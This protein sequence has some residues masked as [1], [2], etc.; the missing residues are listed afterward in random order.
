MTN[1][2]QVVTGRTS[3][4]VVLAVICL[5]Q[6]MTTLD[7]TIVSVALPSIQESVGLTDAGRQ[8]AVTA[9]TL[10]FGGLLLV[11]GRL[12]DLTGRKRAMLI[13]V[14]GFAVASA[15]GGA[16]VNPTMLIAARAL[17]GAFAALIAPAALSLISTT[18]TEAKDRARAFGVFAAAGMSGA[19][20][21]LV[22]GG[23]LTNY[24]GWRWCLYVNIPIALVVVVGGV[25][26][27][28]APPRHPD[29][30]LDVTGAVLCSAGMV[31]LIYG[32]GEAASY[33]WDSGVIIAALALAVVLLTAFV[34]VQAK[35]PN[36]LLPLGVLANR[37]SGTAFL[38]MSISAFST[39]GMLIGM[40]YQLQVVM[41]YTPLKTGLAF[42]AYVLT[43]VTFSTQVATK[44]VRVMK[45]GTMVAIGL[46][47]F[48]VALLYLLRLTPS[49]SYLVDVFPSLILFGCGVGMLTVPAMTTAMSSIDPKYSGVV[50]ALVGASQQ[51]GGSIGA[52]L[53]NTIS[54]SAAGTYLVANPGADSDASVHGF[55]TASVWSAAIAVAG[56]VVVKLAI[57]VDTRKKA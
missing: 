11:S 51:A 54:I 1:P 23:V 50:S 42:L 36:P 46:G 28:P 5:A 14:T 35:S 25:F 29:A 39:Y 8:W 22:T 56:A 17:Q 21:G 15:I 49:S 19:A 20:L 4:V 44:L 10:A 34:R 43:A 3:R 40:T 32:L 55:V 53:L 13:G 45:P 16:A 30:K 6:L 9:Y 48:A 47:A 57:T 41:G 31:A 2:E 26:A 24:L 12:G 7:S 33:G 52:A 27:V 18:F 37:N 38:A